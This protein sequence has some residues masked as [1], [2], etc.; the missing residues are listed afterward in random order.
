MKR[1]WALKSIKILIGWLQIG[2]ILIG[3][4]LA[5]LWAIPI[6]RRWLNNLVIFDKDSITAIVGIT[7]PMTLLAVV[8]IRSKLD[9]LNNKLNTSQSKSEFIFGGATAVS[10]RI[11]TIV[12]SIRSIEQNIRSIEQKKA[13]ILGHTLD[14]AWP[15]VRSW[16]EREDIHD[17]EITLRCIDPDFAFKNKDWLGE[18]VSVEAKRVI[19]TIV[20]YINENKIRLRDKRIKINLA[21]YQALPGIH[22]IMIGDGSLF[23]SFSR[24]GPLDSNRVGGQFYESFNSSDN[25]PRAQAYRRMFKELIQMAEENSRHHNPHEG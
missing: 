13:Y 25:T 2:L 4:T 3:T 5:I 14:S 24:W 9:D 10:T 16:L 12:E 23:I 15:Q 22:G 18:E 7:V 11:N 6:S 17:Y 8:D 21:N 1:E 20:R 19:N